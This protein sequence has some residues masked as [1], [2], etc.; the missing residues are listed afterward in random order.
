MYNN[1][2]FETEDKQ[3]SAI[4]GAIVLKPP[5]CSCLVPVMGV[6]RLDTHQ[7]SPAVW[8]QADNA[9]FG[10]QHIAQIF[11]CISPPGW[12]VQYTKVNGRRGRKHTHRDT[13]CTS[14][15]IRRE[16]VPWCQSPMT[17]CPPSPTASCTD[18]E[19]SPPLYLTN[20]T[21]YLDNMEAL[22]KITQ[23]K[24]CPNLFIWPTS[25]DIWAYW[26]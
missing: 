22:P 3:Y 19:L 16:V 9:I 14:V 5:E 2:H 21:R 20:L 7:R 18:K 23:I 13:E 24:N 15:D 11:N 4:S 17:T 1:A 25:L 12:N 6:T 10:A 26:H 8:Y